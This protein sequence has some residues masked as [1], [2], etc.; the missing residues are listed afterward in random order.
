MK[1]KRKKRL[2]HDAVLRWIR[3]KPRIMI[4]EKRAG[5]GEESWRNDYEYCQEEIR[6]ITEDVPEQTYPPK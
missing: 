3:N 1:T 6:C 2:Q 4:P 5:S